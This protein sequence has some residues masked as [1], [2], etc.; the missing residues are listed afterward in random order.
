MK[1]KI[2]KPNIKEIALFA[3][4]WAVLM[5]AGVPASEGLYL[6]MERRRRPFLERVS[7]KI[8]S[9]YRLSDSFSE[10]RLFPPFFCALLSIGEM[11]GTLP[12]ELHRAAQYY[13]EEY[14]IKEKIKTAC[15]YPAGLFLFLFV[16]MNFFL[17]Y[18][19]PS[20]AGLLSEMGIPL[21]WLT[22]AAL[23]LSDF[24]WHYGAL[25]LILLL[26]CGILLFRYFSRK[27][28]HAFDRWIFRVP[29]L[30]KLY[31]I[32]F[33]LS[34]AALLESGTALSEALDQVAP[35]I[36]N[37]RARGDILRLARGVRNG[38]DF[39]ELLH[40]ASWTHRDMA[41]MVAVG[42]KSGRLPYFL[43]YNSEW[44]MKDV[45]RELERGQKLVEP[46]LILLVG[47]L[48]ALVLFSVMLPIFEALSTFA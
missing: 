21:P 15:Y 42:M 9:G 16:V 12:A 17:L 18:V 44:L 5:E 46:G 40:R 31:L 7:R 22:A 36:G 27:G 14:E 48:V 38:G 26:L 41:G 11:A 35:L 25:L 32:R 13:K 29:L 30:K 34:L 45:R 28:K 33:Q 24:A 2:K 6:L 43:R 8:E 20:F 10:S 4:E 47:L 37:S 3:E 39:C 19:I 23:R 1:R